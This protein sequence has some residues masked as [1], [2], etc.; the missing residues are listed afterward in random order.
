MQK[1]E[2]VPHAGVVLRPS[3]MF[4]QW[5]LSFQDPDH[6]V[7]NL[8]ADVFMIPDLH[9]TH[10]VYDWIR[11]HFTKL[12]IHFLLEWTDKQTQWPDVKDY[13]VFCQFFSIEVIP[14]VWRVN[15]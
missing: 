6:L 9:D 14:M 7:R 2:R 1:I 13:E 12:F 10:G 11:K 4:F 3:E 5:S 8:D 15:V